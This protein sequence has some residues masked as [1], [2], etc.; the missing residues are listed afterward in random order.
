[1]STYVQVLQPDGNRLAQL[2]EAA[3]ADRAHQRVLNS[4]QSEIPL[5]AADVEWIARLYVEQIMALN[6][7]VRALEELTSKLSA[8]IA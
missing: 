6:G 7:V 4:I 8:A 2:Y 1:M 3:V 5:G